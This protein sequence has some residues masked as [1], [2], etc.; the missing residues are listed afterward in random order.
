[1]VNNKLKS[2]V[3][4]IVENQLKANDPKCTRETLNRLIELEYSEKKAKEMIASVV[5]EEIYDVMKNQAPFDEEKYSKKLSKLLDSVEKNKYENSL[6]DVKIQLP[7]KNDPK[8][9][10]NDSCTCGSGKKYKKC[11]GKNI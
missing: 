11:C 10:R 4:D 7:I 8:I 1:M 3:I 5:V 2:A 6:D 9:G